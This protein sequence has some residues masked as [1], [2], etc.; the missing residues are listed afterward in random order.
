MCLV[1][2][3]MT[4]LSTSSEGR[5]RPIS[6]LASADATFTLSKGAFVVTVLRSVNG[7]SVAM[8]AGGFVLRTRS[9]CTFSAICCSNKLIY[10]GFGSR[11]GQL[12]PEQF[13]NGR[14]KEGAIRRQRVNGMVV[15]MNAKSGFIIH[16]F[17]TV[18]SVPASL[19]PLPLHLLAVSFHFRS[20]S[21]SAIPFCLLQSF[22]RL[23]RR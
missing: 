7:Q 6:V 14:D 8:V 17:L 13:V 1:P 19:L 11:V 9:L 15:F 20:G 10:V 2:V 21:R 16:L 3:M 22:R 4:S 5:D 12:A 23:L 18:G